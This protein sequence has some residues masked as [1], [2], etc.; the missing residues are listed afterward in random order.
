MLKIQNLKSEGTRREANYALIRKLPFGRVEKKNISSKYQVRM[1][2]R[3]S[4]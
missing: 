3:S 1:R 2:R 4:W